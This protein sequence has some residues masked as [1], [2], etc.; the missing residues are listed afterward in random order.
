MSSQQLTIHNDNTDLLSKMAVLESKLN[1]YRR[2]KHIIDKYNSDTK[3]KKLIDNY[4]DDMEV[5]NKDGFQQFQDTNK[6]LELMIENKKLELQ[7]IDNILESKKQKLNILDTNISKKLKELQDLDINISKKQKEIQNIEDYKIQF[8]NA[9]KQKFDIFYNKIV[10]IITD[11]CIKVQQ[12]ENYN[13]GYCTF[14]RS[15]INDYKLSEYDGNY[16]ID[17]KWCDYHNQDGSQGHA[18]KYRWEEKA[19]ELP[20][21]M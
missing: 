10:N 12:I 13:S 7:S 2:Y 4:T 17:Y 1:Y 11:E 5:Y 9:D 8:L 3:F 20:K 14:P 15:R 16:Y 6:T 21:I 19:L 18:S